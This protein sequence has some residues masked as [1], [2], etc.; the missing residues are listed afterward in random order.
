MKLISIFIGL[1]YWFFCFILFPAVFLELSE[2]LSLPIYTN[3]FLRF[4]GMLVFVVGLIL[5]TYSYKDLVVK[6]KGTPIPTDPPK[7]LV[8]KGLYNYSR[9]PIYM[10]QWMIL[11]GTCLIFGSVLLYLY[12]ILFI[13]SMH[14]WVLFEERELKKRFGE[15]YSNYEKKVPRYIPHIF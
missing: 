6:G 2:N 1:S 10:T 14:I 5:L 9:N 8:I 4:V 7:N 11:L 15:E 3:T 13:T 12:L